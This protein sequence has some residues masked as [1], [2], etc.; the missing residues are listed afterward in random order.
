MICIKTIRP[1]TFACL[2]VPGVIW[3]PAF[4][5]QLTHLALDKMAAIWQTIFSKTLPWLKKFDFW[6]KFYWSFV[7]M[8]PIDHMPA[9]VQVMA[10]H[11]AGDKAL[12]EPMR[13]QFTD[14]YIYMQHLGE[15]SWHAEAKTKWSHHFVDDDF[16]FIFYV[17]KLLY[18]DS[19]FTGNCSQGPN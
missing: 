5:R 11:R 14:A 12:S 3:W 16:K 13:I 18:L 10:W 9:L 6:L 17:W 15:M 19:N 2:S 8:G 7:P 4:W 1:L